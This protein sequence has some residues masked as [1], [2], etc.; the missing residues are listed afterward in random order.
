MNISTA[1]NTILIRMRQQY[2]INCGWRNHHV[3]CKHTQ[4]IAAYRKY[5]HIHVCLRGTL[6]QTMNRKI[7]ST[8]Q[9]NQPNIVSHTS[10]CKAV[11]SIIISRRYIFT[12][13]P[14]SQIYPHERAESKM[15][16]PIRA[17][18]NFP[19]ATRL[20]LRNLWS[21]VARRKELEKKKKRKRSKKTR[22]HRPQD[23]TC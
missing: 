14:K 23:V 18:R 8:L 2:N 22:Q 13:L 4:N 21:S 1:H 9:V 10:L 17:G 16:F 12:K 11:G 20:R 15:K 6:G 7:N 3:T 5:I 19:F